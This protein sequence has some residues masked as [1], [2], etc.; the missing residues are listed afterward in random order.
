MNTMLGSCEYGNTFDA[1]CINQ[2]IACITFY[3]LFMYL[4]ESAQQYGQ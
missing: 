1:H 4:I 3:V 2:Y